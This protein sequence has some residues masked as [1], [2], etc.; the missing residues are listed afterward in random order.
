VNAR[1]WAGVHY[2]FSVEAGVT[3]GKSVAQ[4]DLARA[5]GLAGRSGK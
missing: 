3:L 5:F 2:R 4:Y 1:V